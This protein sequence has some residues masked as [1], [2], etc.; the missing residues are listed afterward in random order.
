M[1]EKKKRPARKTDRIIPESQLRGIRPYQFKAG[2][3]SPN[4]GGRPGTLR[5]IKALGEQMAPAV[6]QRLFEIVMNPDSNENAA[7]H[8]AREIFNRTYGQAEQAQ[9]N[10]NV[11]GSNGAFADG[12]YTK[13][14]ALLQRA[15]LSQN[16]PKPDGVN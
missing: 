10:L 8:A 13:F 14:S 15:R 6:L 12:D 7:V 2:A 11:D 9:L 1:T 4:P 16:K 5:E 3:P